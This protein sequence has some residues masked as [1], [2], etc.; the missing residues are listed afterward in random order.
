MWCG[1]GS[2]LVGGP[3]CSAGMAGD[4]DGKVDTVSVTTS[5][6]EKS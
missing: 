1:N 3:R 4:G 5:V 2:K 6:E